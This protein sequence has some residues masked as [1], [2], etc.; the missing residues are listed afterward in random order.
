M[1]LR[2]HLY[3]P[4]YNQATGT[5]EPYRG[6]EHTV[7]TMI[8][9]ARGSVDPR[10][11]VRGALDAER[12]VGVRRHTEQIINNL[13]PK[14]YSSEYVAICR[15]WGNAGRYTRDPHHVEMLRDVPRMI[16]DARLR[17]LACDCDEFA[18][19]IAACCL[20]VGGRVQFVTVGFRPRS[21]GQ[22]PIHTHVFTRAQDPRTQVWWVL[23][24]VA[25]RRTGQM[26]SKVKQYSVFEV[27]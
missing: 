23:D 27:D 22:P 6:T 17:R 13:R 11:M 24:P 10:Q 2:A 1:Q 9:L 16:E 7:A 5:T 26:L 21:A 15:W 3:A 14:D 20:A 19:A 12:S 25:G 8:R 18:L 4:Q